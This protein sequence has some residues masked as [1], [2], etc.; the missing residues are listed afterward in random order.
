MEQ[1]TKTEPVA[2]LVDIDRAKGLAIL[3]VVFG[4]LVAGS[5]PSGNE[6]YE[7][8]RSA[9]YSFH[10]A[11]FMFLSGVVFFA[12]LRPVP[13][14][15]EYRQAVGKRFWR[16]MP[17]YFLFAGIVFGG[18]LVAQQYGHVDNPVSGWGDL[19]N[20]VLFPMLSV[21]KFLW[22]VYVLFVFSALALA[23]FT[24]SSGAVWPL[25]VLGACLLWLPPVHLLAIEQMTKYFLFF[26]LGGLAITRW[27]A[28]ATFVD[29]FWLPSAVF[30]VALLL[31]GWY[32]GIRWIVV[33]LLS[34]LA[35]HG[36]CRHELPAS[37]LLLRLGAMT[38][39][40][41]LMNTMSIGMTKAV[42]FKFA[43]WEGA[44]FLVVLPLLF[45]AGVALPVVVK[46]Y[47]FV[48]IRWLDRITS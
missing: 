33:A 48:R 5:A 25:V 30:M 35:L 47:L 6:W 22:Y 12:R 41:Y 29:R 10:M 24:V 32:T 37:G 15:K 16:L 13:G 9:I 8:A 21:S 40:I 23:I 34:I 31:G 19:L 4:H 3:L 28:Y 7:Y 39:P 26:S 45:V 18:K 36:L 38:F 1:K 17:A 2:R 14:I 43:G 11:F 46:R 42:I 44:N 27:S 20:I